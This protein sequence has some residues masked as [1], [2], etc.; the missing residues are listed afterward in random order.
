[1]KMIDLRSDTIT[2]PTPGML[3]A[4]M[5]AKVGD[6]VLGEDPTMNALEEKCAEMF[7]KEAA[8]FCPS[9][10]MSNQIG[11]NILSQPYEEVVCYKG[12]HIYLYEGGGISGNSGLS[13]RLLE[14]DRGR[15]TAEQIEEAINP[16]D[17]HFPKTSVVSLENTVNKG[18]GS[19]YDLQELRKIGALCRSQGL[20][21][22]LD[23]ARLFNAMMAKNQTPSDYAF[24]DTINVSFSKGLGAPVG[25]VLLSDKKRIKQARRMRKVWGGG[26]RQS[27]F[28]AA[29]AIYA[30]D[31]HVQRLMD[32]HQ[33]ATVLASILSG[34]SFVEEVFPVETNIV[35]M[36]LRPGLSNEK[37]L[38]A[39]AEKGIRAIGFGPGLLRMV[40]HLNFTDDQLEDTVKALRPM[41]L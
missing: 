4:M 34:C 30:L 9:G 32:D 37:V 1:M 13:F 39:F 3:D 23:G 10:T 26:M 7:Q 6:D 15:L 31:N 19:C 28:L 12:S 35:I 22:H 29:A 8:L 21:L 20:G 2:T 14:G 27:G 24:F 11:I 36:R 38:Q 33:R 18:G 5:S 17:I 25:S 16:D 40:T 41:V